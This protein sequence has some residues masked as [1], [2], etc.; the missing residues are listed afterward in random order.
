MPLLHGATHRTGPQVV[1]L[2]VV[3][4]TE[5]DG[6]VVVCKAENE[7]KWLNFRELIYY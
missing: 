2:C 5:V 6:T 3:T 4:L 1:D 7:E